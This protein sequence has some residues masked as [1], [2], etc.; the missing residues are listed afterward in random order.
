MKCVMRTAGELHPAEAAAWEPESE[1][2]RQQARNPVALTDYIEGAPGMTG[3]QRH[4][5]TKALRSAGLICQERGAHS[6]H[7]L[8]AK[9]DSGCHYMILSSRETDAHT[10][11]A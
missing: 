10:L 2:L 4:R 1:C 5:K 8:W 9:P 7:Y 3:N 11:R 6:L